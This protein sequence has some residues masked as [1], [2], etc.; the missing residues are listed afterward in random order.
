[1]HLVCPKTLG[2][3]ADPTSRK[4][5]L[6]CP[7]GSFADP[8][9]QVCVSSTFLPIQPVLLFRITSAAISQETASSF[10]TEESSPTQGPDNAFK[11]VLLAFMETIRP[12]DAC[13]TAPNHKVPTLIH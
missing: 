13:K 1:M 2:T 6:Y 7:L 3:Y 10:A 5:V 12:V 11:S 9:T 8:T 4:C